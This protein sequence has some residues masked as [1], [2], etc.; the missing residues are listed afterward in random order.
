[1]QCSDCVTMRAVDVGT[2]DHSQVPATVGAE[3]SGKKGNGHSFRARG[4]AWAGDEGWQPVI[5][6]GG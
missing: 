4:S 2:A 5:A 6:D 3:G 1:L